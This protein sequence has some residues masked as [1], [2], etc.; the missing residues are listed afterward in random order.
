MSSGG[1]GFL[2]STKGNIVYVSICSAIIIKNIFRLAQLTP[3]RFNAVT[4]Q[5]VRPTHKSETPPKPQSCWHWGWLGWDWG[6]ACAPFIKLCTW[7]ACACA[8]HACVWA[9]HNQFGKDF[10]AWFWHSTCWPMSA[11]FKAAPTFCGHLGCP[12]LL[13]IKF[14]YPQCCRRTQFGPNVFLVMS[15]QCAKFFHS[16]P[17]QGH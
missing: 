1:I 13:L 10:E 3:S 4:A 12:T 16:L 8:L 5:P 6:G 11:N 2:I 17:M 14:C 9:W 15:T 7:D